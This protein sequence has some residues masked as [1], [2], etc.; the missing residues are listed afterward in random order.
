MKQGDFVKAINE[1]KVNLF[2][3]E[4]TAEKDYVPYFVNRV[5]SC[6]PDTLFHSNEINMRSHLDKRMQFDY[7]LNSIRQ[8]KRYTPWLQRTKQE[9]LE[10][11][12][13]TYNCSNKKA[14]EFLSILTEEQLL[15]LRERMERG[16]DVN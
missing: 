6:Y 8:K 3:T 4:I 13:Q 5:L 11:V 10:L 2:E 7:F 15:S 14:Q 12:K 9:D 1:T 16:K